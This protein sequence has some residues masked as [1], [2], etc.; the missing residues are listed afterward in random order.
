MIN[1]I[2]FKEQSGTGIIKLNKPETLN[3]L[4]L[5]MAKLF[6]KKLKQ[7]QNDKKIERVLLVSDGK[8]FCAG[9]DVKAMCLSNNVSNLKKQI[10]ESDGRLT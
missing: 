2:L 8:A 4:D 3:A 1:S 5:E 10:D 6:L 9:G 7:W